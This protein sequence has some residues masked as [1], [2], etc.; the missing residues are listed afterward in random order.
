MSAHSPPSLPGQSRGAQASSGRRN[1]SLG[2]AGGT[3]GGPEA[4][5]LLATLGGHCGGGRAPSQ[6]SLAGRL[7]P[8]HL[9]GCPSLSQ[10]RMCQ[11]GRGPCR[12]RVHV[13]RGGPWHEGAKA[14]SPGSGPEL[15]GQEGLPL[16]PPT[17]TIYATLIPDQVS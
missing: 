5:H 2:V 7:N 10:T 8:K 13:V 12:G 17:H 3:L 6:L 9:D 14:H 15:R 4:W 16:L 1:L 11:A